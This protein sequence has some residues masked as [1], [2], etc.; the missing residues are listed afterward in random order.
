MTFDGGTGGQGVAYSLTTKGGKSGFHALAR[1][2][3]TL[4][5]TDGGGQSIF[6]TVYELKP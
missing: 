3:G 4:G 1:C 2:D 5:T 6:G